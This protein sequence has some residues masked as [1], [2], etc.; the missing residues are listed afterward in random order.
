MAQITTSNRPIDNG[1]FIK[2]DGTRSL[3]ADW[4][5]RIETDSISAST[6]INLTSAGLVIDSSSF[7]TDTTTVWFSAGTLDL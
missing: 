6:W 7:T 4:A 2:T 3:S 1:I 5:A